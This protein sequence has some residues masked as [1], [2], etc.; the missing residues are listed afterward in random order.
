M[1][2]DSA[3]ERYAFVSYKS[4]DP[5]SFTG[6]SSLIQYKFRLLNLPVVDHVRR[7]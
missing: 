2:W 6:N 5:P 7:D 3:S 4:S 1:F